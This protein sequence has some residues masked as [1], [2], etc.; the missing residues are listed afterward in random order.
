MSSETVYSQAKT[1]K[2]NYLGKKQLSVQ[3]VITKSDPKIQEEQTKEAS[4]V[5]IPIEIKQ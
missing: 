1:L 2:N 3:V 5:K 4:K